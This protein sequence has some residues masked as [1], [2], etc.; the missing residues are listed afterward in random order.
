MSA[1][2]TPPK[3]S[4]TSHSSGPN[5]TFEVAAAA[6][7]SSWSGWPRWWPWC[8]PSSVTSPGSGP[9]VCGG[10][11]RWSHPRAVCGQTTA[12]CGRVD[13]GCYHW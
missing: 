1:G 9:A 13:L 12:R 2:S 7:S 11:A 8:R 10:G 5:V 4:V 3:S 6:R